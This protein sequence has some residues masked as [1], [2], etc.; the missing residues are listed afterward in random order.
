MTSSHLAPFARTSSEAPAIAITAR[1]CSDEVA[2]I[3]SAIGSLGR[4]AGLDADRRADVALAVSE[5]CANAVIHAYADREP[6]VLRVTADITPDGLEIVIADEGRG[7]APR[8]DS[9]GLGLGLPLMASL[10]SALELRVAD[11][12]GTEIWMVFAT[13]EPGADPSWAVAG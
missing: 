4:R 2:R 5:A 1:A 3:R 8:S 7:M 12:G 9:P 6:G 10:T 11:G 13:H